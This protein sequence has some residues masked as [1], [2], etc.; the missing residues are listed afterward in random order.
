MSNGIV[1]TFNILV[2]QPNAVV[3]VGITFCSKADVFQRRS[4][5]IIAVVNASVIK[6]AMSS[7]PSKSTNVNAFG[8]HW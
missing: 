3:K 6:E 5:A 1:Q 2:V 8:R 7:L 4:E